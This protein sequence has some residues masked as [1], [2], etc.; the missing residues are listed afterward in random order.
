MP[1]QNL[2]LWTFLPVRRQTAV[3]APIQKLQRRQSLG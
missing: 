1:R 3:A 2:P